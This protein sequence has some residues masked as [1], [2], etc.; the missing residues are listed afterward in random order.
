MLCSG[1]PIILRAVWPKRPEC[2]AALSYRRRC[3][4]ELGFSTSS[5]IGAGGKE[6]EALGL[7]QTTGYMSTW[8]PTSPPLVSS[9]AVTT[10]YSPT[11]LRRS[12]AGMAAMSETGGTT[13]CTGRRNV[14]SAL[15]ARDGVCGARGC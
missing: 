1:G 9:S 11:A 5:M 13:N 15:R 2:R 7:T 8:A 3:T 6:F 10:S 12:A 14:G 4:S